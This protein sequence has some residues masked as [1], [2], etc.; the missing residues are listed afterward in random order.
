MFLYIEDKDKIHCMGEFVSA[1]DAA[2][3]GNKLVELFQVDV[4]RCFP[5]KLNN[6][7]LALLKQLTLD[8][9]SYMLMYAESKDEK[10][11]IEGHEITAEQ[12]EKYNTFIVLV[13]ECNFPSFNM[14]SLTE[15]RQ[16]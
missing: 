10:Q 8:V 9:F 1:E 14:K 4:Y 3:T 7:A 15:E 6:E 2:N 13:S 16:S 5:V 12:A 11:A